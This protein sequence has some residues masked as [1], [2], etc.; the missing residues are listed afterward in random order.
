MKQLL[1]FVE[2]G[3]RPELK[4]VV[5]DVAND[6]GIV[7]HTNSIYAGS[8][9][10]GYSSSRFT[11]AGTIIT[12]NE[13]GI[14]RDAG[15][16]LGEIFRCL[17]KNNRHVVFITV[18]DLTCKFRGEN[19]LTFCF[20]LASGGNVVIS[21]ARFNHLVIKE[22]KTIL[23]GL[24]MHELGHLYGIASDPS[25]ANTVD[26]LG[27]HCTN[28][29]CVMQQGTTTELLRKNFNFLRVDN[30]SMVNDGDIMNKYYCPMCT[31]D[32]RKYLSK[33]NQPKIRQLAPL[34]DRKSAKTP[35]PLPRRRKT[36]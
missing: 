11:N 22:Q 9:P 13:F 5:K 14:Q 6:A 29:H 36:K 2:K 35:P 25:R 34:P 12:Q 20:G 1:F 28:R 30:A 33:A 27:M 26:N 16:M 15:K 24:I 8:A 31:E 10:D 21:M 17:S 7:Y 19:Y 32:I 23:A 4:K 18:G 3:L